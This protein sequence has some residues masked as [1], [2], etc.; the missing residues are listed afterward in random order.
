MWEW[1]NFLEF[2][3]IY[4][5]LLEFNWINLTLLFPDVLLS[6]SLP[7]EEGRLRCVSLFLLPLL[8]FSVIAWPQPSPDLGPTSGQ[9][10]LAQSWP[11]LFGGIRFDPLTSRSKVQ[12]ATTKLQW[13]VY[14]ATVISSL[15]S[16]SHVRVRQKKMQS[17]HSFLQSNAGFTLW[18]IKDIIYFIPL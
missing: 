3:W 1:K 9:L 14:K 11:K 6:Q 18:N 17:Q 2:A 8:L 5:N 13:Q 4:L 15:Y 12:L 10:T 7:E 16:K